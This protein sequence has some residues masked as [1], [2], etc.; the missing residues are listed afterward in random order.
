MTIKIKN[1]LAIYLKT[2][3]LTV[4]QKFQQ[5][6][7]ALNSNGLLNQQIMKEAANSIL[8]VM[9]TRIYEHGLAV[10]GSAI[11]TYS[12]RPLYISITE[13][14]AANFGEPTGKTGK[15][16][17]KGG[18]KKVRTTRANILKADITNSKPLLDLMN[19]V[20]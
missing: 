5:K 14:P 8:P 6:L 20:M 3:L 9:R 7:E 13:N 1:V 15:S 2:N 16:R 10:D 11:G 19:P 4:L 18:K 12:T 17:F